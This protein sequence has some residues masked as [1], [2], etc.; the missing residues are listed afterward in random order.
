VLGRAQHVF[1]AEDV[2]GPQS[3]LVRKRRGIGRYLMEAGNRAECMKSGTTPWRTLTA[4]F[5]GQRL[6]SGLVARLLFPSHPSTPLFR[7]RTL[8]RFGASAASSHQRSRDI[9]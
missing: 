5:D 6:P 7:K 2:A 3:Q 1:D 9:L 4:A 8:W